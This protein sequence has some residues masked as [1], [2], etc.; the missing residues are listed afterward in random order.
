MTQ[1]VLDT[2]TVSLLQRG[3]EPIATRVSRYHPDEVA[4]TIKT[5]EEQLSGW[6][7]LL[8]RARTAI[9]LVPVYKRM[10]DTLQ[11][12]SRLPTLTFTEQAAN[13]YEQLRKQQP[14]VGRMDLRIAAIAIS[15]NA[16]LVTRNLSDF[17][18]IVGLTIV[19]WS[20]E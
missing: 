13:V 14:R 16:T 20:R 8:R 6:Y 5:V 1:Y 9:E 4:T 19:D 3:I 15:R 2:D 7:T 11:F 17:E 18:N 10:S 12:L